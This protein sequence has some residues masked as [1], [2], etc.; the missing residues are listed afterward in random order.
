MA[1]STSTTTR[2]TRAKVPPALKAELAGLSQGELE[3]VARLS[4]SLLGGQF[5]AK[6]KVIR[7]ETGGQHERAEAFYDALNDQLFHKLKTRGKP[8]QVLLSQ[9]D[10][11]AKTFLEQ[12]KTFDAFLDDATGDYTLTEAE[13]LKFYGITANLIASALIKAN[14]TFNMGTLINWITHAPSLIN[15]QFPTYIKSGLIHIVAKAA[16]QKKI[17]GHHGAIVEVRRDDELGRLT[18]KERGRQALRQRYKA[19]RDNNKRDAYGVNPNNNK[20]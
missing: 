19:R 12:H 15:R 10:K 18:P 13:R 20:I 3:A 8:L 2:A 6:T 11:V 4:A 5:I 14:V 9:Q 16:M 17:Q 7:A 1:R